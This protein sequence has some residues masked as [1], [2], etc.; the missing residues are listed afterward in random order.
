MQVINHFNYCEDRQKSM[1]K[2]QLLQYLK[3]YF[4][5]C[6]NNP[7]FDNATVSCVIRELDFLYVVIPP[8]IFR[9]FSAV[10]SLTGLKG[11]ANKK[12]GDNLVNALKLT[13]LYLRFVA[14]IRLVQ[15][16]L[17]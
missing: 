1:P 6:V 9:F 2:E 5:K 11:V 16:Q 13:R 3:V 15:D 4:S 8:W 7:L 10:W 14:I 12:G 17:Q